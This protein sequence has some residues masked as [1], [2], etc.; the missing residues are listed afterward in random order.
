M[1]TA[2]ILFN[3]GGPDA[4]ESVRPFLF[5][6]FN[7]KA[8]IGVP[9]PMRYVLAQLI[10]RRRTPHAQEIYQ[11][12]GGKSP[13]LEQTDA[14]AR[15][16]EQRLA[17]LSA[18]AGDGQEWKAFPCMRYWHPMTAEV[19]KQ[20]K[21]YGAERV[22]LLPL[23]PQFSTTTTASSLKLW[24]EEAARQGLKLPTHRWCCY[25][26]EEHFIAS[27]VALI[28]E[29][30]KKLPEGE[31]YRLLFS[32]HGLPE[33][34]VK[35]GDSYQW[36]V[37]QTT[38]AVLKALALPSVD[39]VNCYQ[40]RVGP[41]KWIGPSTEEEI[42]RAG[43]DGKAIVLIPIAFVSEHSE[44]LVEL[45]EEYFHL[46][47]EAGVKTYLRVPALS[48]QAD[49][50]ESLAQLCRKAASASALPCS[51]TGGKICPA[52]FGKCPAKQ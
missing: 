2:I 40:S 1:K 17:E 46:A 43:K 39:Y 4:L 52:E 6:L 22:I 49:Y 7:D 13:L 23:Y 31:A 5:N 38:Q 34:V 18:A 44:T 28:R 10:S 15:H 42:H 14:Q 11:K 16:L 37:E 25:P 35:G 45:D 41:L 12:M 29:T 9:Q 30:L 36:Q 26:T 32:A 19:V 51:H 24:D 47:H 50:I 33:K 48:S 8:I 20:V 27:H 21:E 3:L